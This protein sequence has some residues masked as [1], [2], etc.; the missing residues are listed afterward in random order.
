MPR[1]LYK[2][3]KQISKK[4]GKVDSLHENSRDAKK[5]RRAGGREDKL[6]RAATATTKG[7][8][9]FVDRV[10]FCKEA[11]Q[12][13]PTPLSDEDV[14]QLITRFISRNEPELQQLQSERRPGRPP[15]K[16]EEVLRERIE[17]ENKEFGSG[18]WVPEMG[19][20]DNLKKL[21]AWNGE[22]SAMSTIGFVRV[23]REG[24]KQKSIFPPKGL[25]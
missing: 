11:I 21:A 15:A 9:L 14:V 19:E 2:V 17:A 5:L 6:A 18:F 25:S 10:N 20:T 7:R 12:D 1:N 8:Q 16:R 4:R 22:W 3:Q 23:T 24:V 13:P